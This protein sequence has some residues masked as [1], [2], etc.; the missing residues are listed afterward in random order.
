M[1]K[2]LNIYIKQMTSSEYPPGRPFIEVAS[3][4]SAEGSFHS[5]KRSSNEETLPGLT[6]RKVASNS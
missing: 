3:R 6:A 4:V 5:G 2:K 1:Y